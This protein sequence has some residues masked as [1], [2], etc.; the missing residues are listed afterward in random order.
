MKRIKT[1]QLT[2]FGYNFSVN[3]AFQPTLITNVK[4]NPNKKE[5]E[6]LK[7]IFQKIYFDLAGDKILYDDFYSKGEMESPGHDKMIPPD[8]NLKFE[9]FV[10]RYISRHKGEFA[11][12]GFSLPN[13]Y[14]LQGKRTIIYKGI[15]LLILVN[16]F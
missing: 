16:N 15:P 4:P 9:H 1:G 11:Q 12:R 5:E 3:H 13:R 10:Q 8:Q 14:Q 2:G 7:R 6:R